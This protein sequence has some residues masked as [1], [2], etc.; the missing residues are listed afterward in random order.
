MCTKH[1][2]EA[3]EY[4]RKNRIVMRAIWNPKPCE[5]R[6]NLSKIPKRAM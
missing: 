5:L 1:L 4:K 2:V 3:K 6:L